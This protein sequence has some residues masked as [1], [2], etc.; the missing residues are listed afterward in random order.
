MQNGIDPDL[1]GEDGNTYVDVRALGDDMSAAAIK[2]AGIAQVVRDRVAFLPVR[3]EWSDSRKVWGYYNPLTGLYYPTDALRVAIHAY[4]EFIA[5]GHA[6]PRHFIILD[7]LN[8][9]RVEYYLSDL[10]SLMECP[11]E[12][13]DQQFRLGELAPVHP[14][15]RPLWT[16]SA[17]QI[18][19]G[20]ETSSHEQLFIGRMDS[21]WPLAYHYL[22]LGSSGMVLP[23]HKIT[24]DKVCH[25]ADWARIVPP[26][27]TFT[28]NLSIIGTVNV[29]ETTFSFAPKV[30]DRAFVL[31]F[32]DIDYDA[33]CSTWAGYDAVRQDLLCMAA[34]LR[35]ANLHF[36]YRVVNEILR[37]LSNSAGGWDVHGDFLISAKVLPKL[38]GGEDKLG[39]V[40]PPLLAYALVGP[41]DL[42]Q[43][44][45]LATE[46][47]DLI[48][49]GQPFA[50]LLAH[51]QR[52]HPTYPLSADKVYRMNRQ[53]L[54]SGLASFF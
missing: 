19:M 5:F 53:L 12:I 42:S 1:E 17:P 51:T 14:F 45:Q 9:A 41:Q 28:P 6:A 47:L 49:A 50:Q 15:T 30:L 11:C 13:I 35:S 2:E 33:V 29:D 23:R 20:S 31:E 39:T 37:Y 21:D 27:L 34:I 16:Q 26:R 36:G 8:L 3:P 46:L 25:G 54:D 43:L 18:D 10:L 32:N 22:G 44:H 52:T 38:R 40:L 24:I 7:E 48:A 4:L